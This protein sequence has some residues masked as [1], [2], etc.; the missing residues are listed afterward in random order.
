MIRSRTSIAFLAL[1]SAA[2]SANPASERIRLHPQLHPGQKLMYLVSVETERNIKTES[3]VVVPALPTNARIEVSM[4]LVAEIVRADADGTVLVRTRFEKLSSDIGFGR[5]AEK[6]GPGGQNKEKLE[7]KF[8][9][10]SLAPDGGVA[11]ITGLE[12]FYPEQQEAWRAWLARF[13]AAAALPKDGV[14]PGEKWERQEPETGASPIAGL[15]WLQKSQYVRDEPCGG[16]ALSAMGQES[17]AGQKTDSCAVILVNAKLFQKSAR[18]DAT[19]EA[20]K[21][22]ELKTMGTAGG[23]NETI[24]F[25][26]RTTGLLVRATEDASQSMDV[27]VTLADGSN[28]VHYNLDVRSHSRIVLVL[29]SAL[30]RP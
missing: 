29:D 28:Q 21:L 14:K 22:H 17:Q 4:L 20:F 9:E 30:A 7:D 15:F 2:L 12:K 5:P 10:F 27:V 3:R 23:S 18:K 1:F 16:V 26:S 6:T 25:I 11:N 24:H 8:V 13:T 19:P